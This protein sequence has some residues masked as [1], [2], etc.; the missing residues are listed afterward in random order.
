MYRRLAEMT[1]QSVHGAGA[2]GTQLVQEAGIS[3]ELKRMLE[4]RITMS[5]LKN[6]DASIP[7]RLS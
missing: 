3:E 6:K 4:E 7:V 1:E 5:G 2:R